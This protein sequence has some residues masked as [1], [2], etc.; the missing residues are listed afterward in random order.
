MA[1]ERNLSLLCLAY[2]NSFEMSQRDLRP[3]STRSNVTGRRQVKI[4]RPCNQ[5][6]KN[7]YIYNSRK[8]WN[9]LPTWYHKMSNIGQF[10][11]FVGLD[12]ELLEELHE[13]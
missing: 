10:K 9:S 11:K 2:R 4:P 7:S 6:Y 8:W 3:L 12:N 5:I 1:Y 13:I